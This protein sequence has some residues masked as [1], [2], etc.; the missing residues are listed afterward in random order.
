MERHD[1]NA[2]SFAEQIGVGRSSISHILSGRNKPSLDFIMSVLKQFP[3]VDLYWLLNGKGT[4]STSEVL[5]KSP[6][7]VTPTDSGSGKKRLEEPQAN[8]STSIDPVKNESTETTN[9]LTSTLSKKGK[10]ITKVILI[11]DD[12]TFEAFDS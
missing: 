8:T 3:D 11:Y 5:E 2:S 1:L 4:Y 6:Q 12:C 7:I 10:N 9:L